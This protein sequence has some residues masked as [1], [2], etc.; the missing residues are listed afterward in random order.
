ME[1]ADEEELF[2]QN[3]TVGGLMLRDVTDVAVKPV[4][5]EPVPV[6]TTQT[7]PAI[8]RIASLNILVRD[9]YSQ[10]TDSLDMTGLIKT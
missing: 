4:L 1:A 10:T 9:E 8:L 3:S 2:T 7:V 6:V 5:E